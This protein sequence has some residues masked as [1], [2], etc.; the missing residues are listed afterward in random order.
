M[1][2]KDSSLQFGLQ[3][4]LIAGGSAHSCIWSDIWQGIEFLSSSEHMLGSG[5]LES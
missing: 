3:L 4:L 5:P 2:S 1:G